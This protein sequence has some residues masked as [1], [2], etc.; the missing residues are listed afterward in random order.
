[1]VQALTTMAA[2]VAAKTTA[3]ADADNNNLK[4]E[5]RTP[6]RVSFFETKKVSA[7]DNRLLFCPRPYCASSFINFSVV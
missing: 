1:M 4:K 3:D 7:Y 6:K 2:A 5:K